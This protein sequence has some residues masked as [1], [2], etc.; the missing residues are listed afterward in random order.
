VLALVVRS[1]ADWSRFRK[2]VE[3]ALSELTGNVSSPS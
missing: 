1:V 3:D 2:L